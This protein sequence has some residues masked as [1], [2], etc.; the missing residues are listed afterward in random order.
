MTTEMVPH[1]CQVH[2]SAFA[3]HM[4][5]R[6][7]STYVQAFMSWFLRTGNTIAIVAVDQSN[8]VIGYVVGAPVGY[9]ATM[10]R[11]LGWVAARSMLAHP[12]LLFDGQVHKTVAARLGQIFKP[13]TDDDSDLP[14]PTMSLVGIGVAPA[15]VGRRIGRALMQGFEENARRLGMASLRL[16]VYR[17]NTA[18]QRLYENCGWQAMATSSSATGTIYYGRVLQLP[19]GAIADEQHFTR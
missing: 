10:S 17:G 11:D 3:G 4:S 12:R 5:A 19:S 2:L 1:V 6:L 15:E 16:S 7:G 13:V 18:A 8:S 9:S 14:S